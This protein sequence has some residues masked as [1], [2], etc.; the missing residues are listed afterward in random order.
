MRSSQD[1]LAIRL[2][3]AEANPTVTAFQRNLAESY[4]TLAQIHR[5]TGN[6]AGGDSVERAGSDH[7]PEAGGREPEVPEFLGDLGRSLFNTGLLQRASGD[8]AGA[9]NS[10]EEA[11][12]V[13]GKKQ[14]LNMD[15]MYGEERPRPDL[16][17]GRSG[18]ASDKR[19]RW[20]GAAPSPGAPRLASAT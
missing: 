17:A 2:R 19:R 15:E 14:R 18:R 12:K 7:L 10:F 16:R 9:L 1:A 4:S 20:V 3:L 11:V 6:L 13:L 5:K 8:A